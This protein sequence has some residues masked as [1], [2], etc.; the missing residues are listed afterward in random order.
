MKRI[1]IL[2][3]KD[4]NACYAYSSVTELAKRNSYEAL[5]IGVPALW[6]ALSKRKGR[7]ENKKCLIY[8]QAIEAWGSTCWE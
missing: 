8:Y 4:S 6:N 3:F 1:V 5:G 7:F 2:K